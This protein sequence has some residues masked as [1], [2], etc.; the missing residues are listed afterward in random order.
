MPD[1]SLWAENGGLIGLIIGALFLLVA[2][3]PFILRKMLKDEREERRE[4]RVDYSLNLD[5]VSQR[6]EKA[7][8]KVANALDRLSN[9]L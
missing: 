1:A 6:N 9:K 7:M 8:E 3:F 5:Q 4:T 2:T